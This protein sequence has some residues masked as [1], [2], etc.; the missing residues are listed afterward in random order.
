MTK[1][2]FELIAGVLK[3]LRLDKVEHDQMSVQ[4]LKYVIVDDFAKALAKTNPR[5]DWKKFIEA[6]IP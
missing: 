6:S 1:K 3:A 5:F 4:Q 2:D